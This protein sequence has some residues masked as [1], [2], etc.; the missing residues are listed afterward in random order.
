MNATEK[1]DRIAEDLAELRGKVKFITYELH[2]LLSVAAATF[3]KF[4]LFKG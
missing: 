1:I 3:I 2:L 4:M